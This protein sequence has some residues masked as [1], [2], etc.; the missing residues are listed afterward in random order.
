M[1][2]A[3]QLTERDRRL[4]QMVA[5]YRAVTIAQLRRRFFATPGG[6]SAGYARIKRLVQ[7]K[8]LLAQR[9]G[10]LSGIGSGKTLLT[11][12]R[13]GQRLVTGL[14]DDASP[15]VGRAPRL[16]ALGTIAHHLAIGDVR[17]SL[18]LAVEQ[19]RRFRRIAWRPEH[20]LAAAPLRIPDP[21]SGQTFT[22]IPDGALQLELCDGRTQSFLVELDRGTIPGTRLRP[23]L[24]AYLR[25]VP[26]LPVLFIVP[27]ARRQVMIR[28][29]TL[30]EAGRIG[31]DPTRIWLTTSAQMTEAAVLAQPIW[32]VVGGPVA[33]ALTALVDRHDE[34]TV[35]DEPSER[36][37][38]PK[39]SSGG[40]A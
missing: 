9:L 16:R 28:S 18:E 20:E 34:P 40:H 22:G 6:R 2:H 33:L 35:Y 26:P 21:E 24:R 17:L 30:A 31:A 29:W 23:K 3:V 27:D 32:Q 38:D 15:R 36:D 5:R 37:Q 25:Q 19:S 7:A 12:G 4:L 39:P 11:L 10:S 1:S 13:P 8:Y 14:P